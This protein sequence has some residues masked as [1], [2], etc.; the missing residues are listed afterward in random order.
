MQAR[1]H[2]ACFEN[3]RHPAVE[4]DHPSEHGRIPAKACCLFCG[5]RLPI[6]GRHPYCLDVGDQLP[7]Q[8]FWS[9]AQCLLSR[10]EPALVERL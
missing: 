3:L 10:F 4:P 8:R 1:A 9:H 5:E 7:P 2:T 6:V